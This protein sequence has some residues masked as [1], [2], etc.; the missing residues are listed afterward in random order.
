MV[1]MLGMVTMRPVTIQHGRAMHKYAVDAW[2]MGTVGSNVC[3]LVTSTAE[4]VGHELVDVNRVVAS[5]AA[6][7]ELDV[8]QATA[9]INTDSSGARCDG[10]FDAV[11][12]YDEMLN[13]A[14]V[15]VVADLVAFVAGNGAPYLIARLCRSAPP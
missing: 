7:G 1:T 10:V 2:S 13:G 14:Y 6:G 3:V 5:A 4:H 15:A 11:G 8:L 9:A 12:P